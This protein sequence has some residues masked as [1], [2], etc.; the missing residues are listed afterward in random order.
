MKYWV[1]TP[2][3][4]VDT[5]I[6]ARMKELA[7]SIQSTG[8]IKKLAQELQSAAAG[9]VWLHYFC[10][11]LISSHRW[12]LYVQL[13]SPSRPHTKTSQKPTVPNKPRDLAIALLILEGDNYARILQADYISYFQLKPGENHVRDALETNYTITCWVKQA[14]LGC[15]ELNARSVLLKF[16]VSTAEV[17]RHGDPVHVTV[18]NHNVHRN[19]VNCLILHPCQQFWLLY[20]QRQSLV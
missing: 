4:E 14:V 19:L 2:Y 17:T 12:L 7:A 8:K 9:R 15:D 16:F 6:L 1:T 20:G 18:A 13:I 10:Q 11:C 5:N 3:F